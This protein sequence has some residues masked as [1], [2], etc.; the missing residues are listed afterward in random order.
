MWFFSS[1]RTLVLATLAQLTGF[2]IVLGQAPRVVLS[3]VMPQN[4]MTLG[5]E[6]GDFPDWVE[7][8]N[9]GSVSVSLSGYSLSDDLEAPRKWELPG[10]VLEPGQSLVVFCSGK[11]RRRLPSR[12][13]AG[14]WDP[15]EAGG[16]VLWLDAQSSQSLVSEGEHLAVWEDRSGKGASAFQAEPTR[17]PTLGRRGPHRAPVVE[18]DGL[19]DYLE[20]PQ[21]SQVRT[22]FWVGD[23]SVNASN[24]ARAILGHEQ[25]FDFHRGSN[26]VMFAPR[27]TDAIRSGLTFLDDTPV[28]PWLAPFPNRLSVLSIHPQSALRAS[29]IGS[30]RRLTDRSWHGGLGE[31]LFFD[32]RFSTEESERARQYLFSKW[33]LPAHY[34]HTNFRLRAETETIALFD[35]GHQLVDALRFDDLKPDV[36]AGRASSG[37]F[38]RL[39]FEVPTPWQ[40]NP[41]EGFRGVVAVPELSL[42]PG[43]YDRPVT[44]RVGKT[45]SEAVVRFTTDGS[46]PDTSSPR[47]PQTLTISET[48]SFRIAAFR[49]GF[50]ASRDVVLTFLIDADSTIPQVALTTDPHHLFSVESGIYEMGKGASPLLPHYGANFWRDWER[51]VAVEVFGAGGERLLSQ[52]AGIKIHGG[53]SRAS[54]QKSLALIARGTYGDNRFRLPVFPEKPISEFKQWLLRNSGNDWVRTLFRDGLGH[55]LA[56]RIGLDCQAHQPV[57]VHLN[58]DYWGIYNLRER[59]NEHFLIENHRLDSGEIDLIEG[60]SFVLAGTRDSFDRLLEFLRLGEPLHDE[61]LEGAMQ[62]IDVDNFFTYM[63]LQFYIDN[64]DW[65]GNNVRL[66]TTR[67]GRGRWRWVPYDLDGGFDIRHEG[68]HRN[69]VS[70]VLGNREAQ[71]KPFWITFIFQRLL[72]NQGLEQRFVQRMQDLL[73]TEFSPPQVLQQIQKMASTLGPEIDRHIR[74]RGGSDSLG[75]VSFDSVDS[76]A[77]NIDVMKRFAIL[78]PGI[79][80]SQIQEAFGKGDPVE[81]VVRMPDPSQARITMNGIE[82]PAESDRW[83]GAFFPGSELEFDVVARPGFQFMGWHDQPS[84]G[85]RRRLIVTT[86]DVVEPI[87]GGSPDGATMSRAF[88]LREGPF[89][90]QALVSET[91]P[92]LTQYLRFGGREAQDRPVDEAEEWAH[93]LDR[94]VGSRFQARQGDGVSMV[95]EPTPQ[96]GEGAGHANSV[97]VVI[98]TEGVGSGKLSWVAQSLSRGVGSYGL[99]PEF[100]VSPE[101]GF[102]AFPHVDPEDLLFR[103]EAPFEDLRRFDAI[104]LP[105]EMLERPW[106]ELRWVYGPLGELTEGGRRSEIRLDDIVIRAEGQDLSGIEKAIVINEIHYHPDTR[107]PADEFVELHNVGGRS[108]ELAGWRLSGGIDFEFTDQR[109]APGEFMVVAADQARFIDRFGGELRVVGDWQGRLSNRGET[110]NLRNGL[111]HRVDRVSYAD[112]GDW[113]TRVRGSLDHGHRGWMWSDAH[114][115]GGHTLELVAP[116]LSNNQGLNWDASRS[117]WGTPGRPNSVFQ[118]NGPPLVSRVQQVPVLPRSNQAV[119]VTARVRDEQVGSVS[120]TLSYRSGREGDFIPLTMRDDGHHGDGASGDGIFGA[121]IPPQPSQTVVSFAIEAVDSLGQRKGWPRFDAD[122]LEGAP[123]ALYQVT[124]DSPPTD[125]PLHRIILAEGEREELERIGELP[126]NRSSDAQMNATFISQQGG[127]VQL[128]YL[129]GFRLRGSTSRNA[130]VKNRRIH[131]RSDQTWKG[132]RAIILN[133]VNVPSQIIGSQ[134]FRMAGVPAPAA[135]PVRLLENGVNRANP[136]GQQFGHY[137]ELEVLDDVFVDRQFPDDVGGNLYRPSGFGNLEYLGPDPDAYQAPGFYRKATNEERQE[138]GDLIELTRRLEQSSDDAYFGA[139]DAVADVDRWVSYFA[140][141]TLLANLETSF[142]NGGAGDYLLYVGPRRQKA[143][144]IAYDLDSLWL[145]NPSSVRQDLF[146][147]GANPVPERFLKHPAVA[148]L[149]HGRLRELAGTVFDPE[150]LGHHLETVLGAWVA[151]EE[152][153]RLK[154]LSQERRDFVLASSLRPLHVDINRPFVEPA[155]LRYFLEASETLSLRGWV[156]PVE[157]DALRV[158]GVPAVLTPWSG[159]WMVSGV[160]L[161]GGVNDIVVDAS[162]SGTVIESRVFNVYRPGTGQMVSRGELTEDMTWRPSSSPVIL[163]ETLRVPKGRTLTILPGTSVEFNRGSRLIVSGRL[164]AEGTPTQRIHLSRNRRETTRWGGVH[165]DGGTGR[166][167]NATIEWAE[168]PTI[169][170]TNATISLRGLRW[171]GAFDS[172]VLTRDSS[173]SIRDSVFP[174]AIRG[175]PVTGLGVPAGGFWILE[176]N[177]FGS[178][179]GGG[180]I[181]DF[182]G[183]RRGDSMLQ[184]YDNV[185]LGG[186]DDGLDLDGSDALIDGNVFMNFQKANAGTGDAHAISTGLYNGKRSDLTVIRNVFV[187]NEHALLMKEGAVA[188]FDHNTVVRSSLGAINFAEV[189]RR[190]FPPDRLTIRN[191]IIWEGPLYRHLEIAQSLNPALQPV[192]ENSLYYPAPEEPEGDHLFVDPEFLDEVSDFR[193]RPTSPAIGAGPNGEDLGAFVGAGAVVTGEPPFQTSRRSAMLFV[194]GAGLDRYRFRINGGAFGEVRLLEQPIVLEDLATGPVQVEVIGRNVAGRWQEEADATASRTWFVNPAHPAVRINE[195]LAHNRSAFSVAGEFPDYLEFYNDGDV[196][197]DLSWSQLSDSQDEPDRFV[198]PP[199][200]VLEPGAFLLVYADGREAMPG[201]HAGFRLGRKGGGVFLREPRSDGGALIDSIE[202]G[203]QAS[204]FSIGRT[205]SG[206]WSL[207]HSTPMAQNRNVTLAGNDA[208][209]INEWLASPLEDENDFV[210]VH[211]GSPHPVDLSGLALSP[212]PAL[213]H[214]V[215]PFARHSY[216]APNEFFV[217]SGGD[218]LRSE[219]WPLPF[220]LP[221]AQG[222]LALIDPAGRVIDQVAYGYLQPGQSQER[223]PAGGLAIQGHFF[224]SPGRAFPNRSS[225]DGLVLNEVVAD[226]REFPVAGARFPDWVELHNRSDQAVSLHGLTLTDDLSRPRRWAFPEEAR[227]AAGAYS[228]VRFDAGSAPGAENTGFGL[229]AD[230]DAVYLLAS[231]ESGFELLDEIRFGIQAPGWSLSRF[232][233]VNGWSLGMPTPGEPNERVGLGAPERVRVNEWMA[234]PKEGSDWFELFNGNEVPVALGGLFLTDDPGQVD[235]FRIPDHSYIGSGLFSYTS[236]SA[237]GNPERGGSH[238]NFRLSAKGESIG[239]YF[240]HGSL[241]DEVR[242]VDQQRN[243]SQGRAPDGSDRIVSFPKQASRGRENVFDLDEDRIADSWEQRFGLN[244]ASGTDAGEDPDGD[245]IR[246]WEEYLANTDPLD[247][248]SRLVIRRFT[249]EESSIIVHFSAEAGREY[250]VQAT[251]TLGSDAWTPLHRIKPLA[252]RLDLEVPVRLD[253]RWAFFRIMAR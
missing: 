93:G 214:R 148:R 22:V 98:N 79:V 197:Y 4:R 110:V 32:R 152:I 146:R 44:L 201:L 60:D 89:V 135:R 206:A 178:T 153:D 83:M 64:T 18:F 227:L 198:F 94:T 129:V 112:E 171:S 187:D 200:T 177:Q 90:F 228:V 168:A 136:R 1:W 9:P 113:A 156:D 57:H 222:M 223:I 224:P 167:H 190:T 61:F 71:F 68:P 137:A 111:G 120:V 142:A 211:N 154:S 150:R 70:K 92:R 165:F 100:R 37:S 41:D 234:Q 52:N 131:F 123:L 45:H 235:Q 175:E 21:I 240:D 12:I 8:Y 186:P 172:F 218:R 188:T 132:R 161:T 50:V 119:T 250:E 108:I 82:L 103:S 116:H 237:D 78:R 226:N 65:P 109:M 192:F 245:G 54:P 125:R 251:R 249:I 62:Q 225:R 25:H 233:Q 139:L 246:N 191:S 174:D 106:V 20:I 76:W 97:S 38:R 72:Q 121:E 179:G 28:D 145:P 151:E 58:G 183:G 69:L 236:F 102:Q 180:D 215:A 124:D 138:W 193:L 63:A 126:W 33:N 87:L 238:V 56:G 42:P 169:T 115:G 220:P 13:P 203:R 182:T 199:G 84:A 127:E 162:L 144:L 195:V 23:E 140:T 118:E 43:R 86:A 173:V 5:D 73:N 170:A 164:E 81:V 2:G 107:N 244:P 17:R 53:W 155:W 184:I 39:V 128:R 114:D 24:S 6:D 15:L 91:V 88:P 40:K 95:N 11:D 14:G 207:G 160:P 219:E 194:S 204:D 158:N 205:E 212:E 134:L 10:L 166:L 46:A 3:E 196:P 19:D 157:V 96:R 51:P 130:P 243:V 231:R 230:G 105:S 30:D 232:S 16:L 247:A 67:D 252:R 216:I 209:R 176:G 147:A 213:R 149:Y 7:L 122:T 242:F 36:S 141:D 189:Q 27:H 117:P 34:L 29:L 241:I 210:E 80:G 35:G 163:N 133:A 248:S 253:E 185:F 104:P 49:P 48:T 221:R 66:W 101:A 85:P 55:R 143:Y 74:R 99:W 31:L 239:L 47:F 181:V 75:Y 202:Y 59:L 26:R 229:K 208:L 159:S 217:L 77:E